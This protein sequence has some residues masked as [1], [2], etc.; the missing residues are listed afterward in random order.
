ME[1]PATGG[2]EGNNESYLASPLGLDGA[3]RETRVKHKEKHL[4]NF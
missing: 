1:G 3:T 4:G 2:W